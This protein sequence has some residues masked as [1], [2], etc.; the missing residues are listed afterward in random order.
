MVPPVACKIST[1]D[2]T[3]ARVVDAWP[4][5]PA[6]IRQSITAFVDASTPTK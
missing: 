6:H 2:P 4:S 3:L 1:T 5:L